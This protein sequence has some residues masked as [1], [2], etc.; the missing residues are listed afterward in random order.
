MVHIR[1]QISKQNKASGS[2]S[3]GQALSVEGTAHS[4]FGSRPFRWTCIYVV[5]KHWQNTKRMPYIGPYLSKK[6]AVGVSASCDTKIKD[7][8]KAST[9]K[10]N[11]KWINHLDVPLVTEKD[12]N[13]RGMDVFFQ[14]SVDTGRLPENIRIAHITYVFKECKDKSNNYRE[15][16]LSLVMG[17]FWEMMIWDR[18]SIQQQMWI[19][20]QY[21]LLISK[22]CSIN[23]IGFLMKSENPEGKCSWQGSKT[24]KRCLIK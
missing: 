11:L 17:E 8:W 12:E 24:C 14:T 16:S 22:S 13:F 2:Q 23:F 21:G 4:W 20:S 3:M 18:I 7:S 5:R 10:I 19:E 6:N 9:W 15:V 1:D